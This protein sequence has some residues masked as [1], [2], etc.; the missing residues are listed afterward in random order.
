M[1][2]FKS[3]IEQADFVDSVLNEFNA[4]APSLQADPSTHKTW[5]AKKPEILQMWRNLRPDTPIIIQPMADTPSL[6]HKS[7]YS[8]DG[9][10]ITGSYQFISSIMA[11]LKEIIGYENPQTKLRLV[12]RGIDKKDA[13][14]D[15]QS[16]VFYVNL[17]S[18]A[19]QK[20]PKLEPN[21]T[22]QMPGPTA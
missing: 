11:R 15:R 2:S 8:E 16:F 13:R 4:S 19:R 12:F 22:P 7:S 10:R 20:P 1:N 9:I 5:S 21:V 14:P 17:E 18:R 3:F 6:T